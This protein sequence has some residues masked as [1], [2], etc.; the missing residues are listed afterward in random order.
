MHPAG[1][2]LESLPKYSIVQHPADIDRHSWLEE[3][4]CCMIELEPI[5]KRMYKSKASHLDVPEHLKPPICIEEAAGFHKRVKR[6]HD[7]MKI[8]GSLLYL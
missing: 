4:S 8:F 3:L 1:K 2:D 5:E 7:P 6:I